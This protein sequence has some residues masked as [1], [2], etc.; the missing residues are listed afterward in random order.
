VPKPATVKTPQFDLLVSSVEDYAI[1]MLDEEGRVTSWNAGAERIKGY[2]SSEIVG[3]SI[4][5]FYMDW[6]RSLKPRMLLQKAADSGSVEDEGWRVRKDGSRFWAHVSITALRDDGGNLLGFAKITADQ[7]QRRATQEALRQSEERFSTAFEHA[8]IGIGLVETGGRFIRVNRA[9]CRMLGY[10]LDEFLRLDYQTITHPD[11]LAANL[12]YSEQLLRG[13]INSYQMERRYLCKNGE[14]MWGSLSVSLVRET[15][16]KPRHFIT[17][18]EDISKKREALDALRSQTA[19]LETVIDAMGS[20]L[21][22]VSQGKYLIVNRMA[23]EIMGHVSKDKGPEEWR[24]EHD[25]FLPDKT[26][27]FD[28]ENLPVRRALRGENAE[29][30]EIWMQSK[31]AGAGKWI[32]AAGRPLFDSRGAVSGA[33]VVFRDVTG[34]KT[35][36][37]DLELSR[38][39]S[40]SNARLSALG[41]MAGSIAHEINNPL[42]IIHGAATNLMDL[43]ANPAPATE[44]LQ[45]N[46]DRILRTAER[47][48]RIVKSLR[49]IAREGN[50]DPLRQKPL[51]LILEETLEL[52]RERFRHHEVELK[53]SP[54]DPGLQVRCREVQVEQTLLNLLQNAFDAVNERA[55]EKWVHLE[56]ETTGGMVSISVI[57]SGP[58]ISPE[59]RP[60]IFEPFFTTKPVG[61]GTGLGLNISKTIAEEHG[62]KLEMSERAGKTCFTLTL[63]LA[64][65]TADESERSHHSYR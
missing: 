35:L 22:V 56:V 50:S 27:P 23:H 30:T 32:R 37:N 48:A 53:T 31:N 47:I 58:G 61:K 33:V 41:R 55:G 2:A 12:A 51:Q 40:V 20:G 8:P 17:Q 16:G 43:L 45:K 10:S 65:E 44:I 57:D 54:I 38:A 19:L 3:K 11:D 60:H 36:E 25:L 64:G 6:E 7:T 4:E 24:M 49:Q 63:Q 9:L 29:E 59:A 26:T 52:C 46:G 13:E 34:Q 18:I 39:Q 15:S 28:P 62:G 1:F 42:A 5:V 14:M 21:V